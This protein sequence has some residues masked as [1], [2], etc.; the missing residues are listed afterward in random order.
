MI[1]ADLQVRML[2]EFSIRLCSA[3]ISD[4]DNRSR[5]VWLLLAYMIYSRNRSICQSDLTR[6]LWGEEEGDSNLLN[7]L[8]TM[9]YR[10]RTT[11][12]QLD[13]RAG[14]TLIVRRDGNYAWNRDI[15]F[16]FDVEK[17]DSLCKA[18]A[19]QEDPDRK[20]DLYL[21][22]L[23]LYGGDFLSKLS[24]EPWVIPIAD[25]FHNLYLQTVLE[26]LSLLEKASR[27]GEA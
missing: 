23:S 15:P 8:K 9:F 24:A 5:K 3:E 25:Y 1:P 22:A 18:G 7:S 26:T 17:F 20:L 11:L 10:V 6:L 16:F 19:T 27:L 12:N 21:Q 13:S 14:H 4:S 2:G